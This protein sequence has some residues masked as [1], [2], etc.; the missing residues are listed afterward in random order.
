MRILV[1]VDESEHSRRAVRYVGTLLA[2]TPDVAVTLFH[3]LKPVPRE[4][5]E[6]GGSERPEVEAALSD[7]LQ[8]ER[9]EWIRQE[10]ER[11]C[12]ILQDAR[13]AM[14][15]TGLDPARVTLQFGQEDD[16]A[17][18]ILEAARIGKH[19]TIAVGRQGASGIRRIFGGGITD[20][21][22]RRAQGLTLW[23]VD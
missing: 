13:R 2:R 1:A 17:G 10:E 19:E 21:L 16:V 7:H 15:E 4:L 5:L 22:L 9:R 12:P 8:R 20:Q 18:N 23:I 11:E 14:A 3:V 6:H